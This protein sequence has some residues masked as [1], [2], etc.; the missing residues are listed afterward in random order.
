[1]SESTDESNPDHDATEEQAQA[2]S[3]RIPN[4][5]PGAISGL[6]H[7]LLSPDAAAADE[8][9]DE[10]EAGVEVPDGDL[11]YRL[12]W[13]KDAEDDTER[14]ERADAVWA[15]E[16]AANTDEDHLSD[17]AQKLR[18]AVN[19]TTEAIAAQEGNEA[20][21]EPVVGEIVESETAGTGGAVNAETGQETA[22]GEPLPEVI[23]PGTPLTSD[24]D[25]NLRTPDGDLYDGPVME[26]A[27][28]T[29]PLTTTPLE[30]PETDG[31]DSPPDGPA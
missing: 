30:T 24:E 8:S 25:G 23:A 31:Q 4:V 13:V 7:V 2:P 5:R 26:S 14:S 27:E 18:D 9:P 12:A 21:G 29:E 22:P 1:M 19:G 11:D 6:D 15:A 20:L 28:G 3:V 10:D 16:S 17:V